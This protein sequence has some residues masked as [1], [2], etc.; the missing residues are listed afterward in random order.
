MDLLIVLLIGS[1]LLSGLML[2]T[3][4]RAVFLAYP[5]QTISSSKAIIVTLGMAGFSMLL[6]GV[7]PYLYLRFM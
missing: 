1:C 5:K 7:L 4:V 6:A 3:I 2:L